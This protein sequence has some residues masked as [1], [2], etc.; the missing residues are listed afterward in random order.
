MWGALAALCGLIDTA[1]EFYWVR[2]FLGIAQAGFFPG[3]LVYLTHWFRQ[4]DRAKAVA[5]V[6]D[7]DPDVEHARRRDRGAAPDAHRLA[8]DGTAGDGC[9]SWRASDGGPRIVAFFYLTDRPE[10]R[11]LA[12]RRRAPVDHRRARREKES[13]KAAKKL[14]TLEALRQPQVFILALT[15]FCYITNSVG[16]GSW[17][18]KIVRR[19]SGL[20]TT[21]VILISGIPWMVAIPLMLITAWHSDKTGERRWHAALPLFLV[22]VGLSLSI[23]AGNHI[24]LAIAAFSV[25]TMAL[26]SFPSPF[27]TLPTL[28]LTGPAAAASIALINATGNLGGFAGPTSSAISPI[29]PAAIPRADLSGDVRA[30]RQRAGALAADCATGRGNSTEGPRATARRGSAM[31][32]DRPSS[33]RPSSTHP[34][35]NRGTPEPRTKNRVAWHRSCPAHWHASAKAFRNPRVHEVAED[36][37]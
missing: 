14:S 35:A 20:S 21:Q 28:F 22:G 9:S 23:A 1:S 2:F 8:R 17:L 4:E 31:I 34:P 13:K 30:D 32:V 27:W 19:I 3:V 5:H 15:C 6:H 11:A 25:A 18:P 37:W 33:S 29:S 26:Y 12:A 16:L 24:V 10:R 36:G 7:G